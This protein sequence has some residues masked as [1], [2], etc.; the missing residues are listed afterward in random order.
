MAPCK[1]IAIGNPGAGKSTFG[2]CLMGK[3]V[4]DAK[5]S[6]DGNSVT[7]EMSQYDGEKYRFVD[8]PGL[9]DP[10]DERRKT[11]AAA[12]TKSLQEE[13]DTKILFFVRTFQGRIITEDKVT[14][15]RVA[16]AMGENLQE[17]KYGIIINQFPKKLFENMTEA[18]ATEWI[19]K[20]LAGLDED[21][22]TRHVFFNLHDDD[23]N[24]AENT[25]KPLPET[26]LDAIDKIPMIRMN[27]AEVQAVNIEDWESARA[28]MER[29]QEGWNDVLRGLVKR[30]GHK[31]IDIVEDMALNLI[32][33]MAL[34]RGGA[35]GPMALLR[36]IVTRRE[37]QSTQGD[38]PSLRE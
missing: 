24:F 9:A 2:N 37:S 23:L 33:P 5:L 36:Q 12:I 13:V 25:V 21:K 28:A 29:Y 22:W 16:D 3:P 27:P 35:N 30:A 1:L 38:V 7:T 20:V 19:A 32:G 26:I 15:R 14:M 31:G 18:K 6:E 34:L 4:F 11:A 8:V 17:D 10:D